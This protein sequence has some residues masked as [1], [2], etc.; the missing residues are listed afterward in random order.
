MLDAFD[1]IYCGPPP[2]PDG[3][4]LLWNLDPPLLLA[5][6]ALAVTIGRCRPG[7]AAVAVLVVVF[8]SPLCAL[9][10]ALFA[11]RSAHHILLVAVAAP[12]IAAALPAP[13]RVSAAL[14]FAISTALLWIWHL[15]GAYDLALANVA[16]YWGMQLSLLL[17]AVAFWRAVLAPDAQPAGAVLFVVA[18]FVQ[19]A[20][21]GAVLT[22][23]P[24]PLYAIHQTAPLAWGLDPLADQQLGGLLMWVPAGVPYAV[25]AAVLARRMWA[26]V[27]RAAS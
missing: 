3:L 26:L 4:L 5:L 25:V 11:A 13:R 1:G 12:L 18:G 2:G 15:P 7:A 14:P 17:S 8:V 16:V 10:S 20:L 6:A 27:G 21:L 23:A 24:D 22:F 9:S 19:M